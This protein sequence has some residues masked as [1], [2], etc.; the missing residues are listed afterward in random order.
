M[1]CGVYGDKTFCGVTR[2]GVHRI[3]F[4][5]NPAGQ[6]V[7]T[8]A[9]FKAKEFATVVEKYLHEHPVVA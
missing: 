7:H 6:V 4:L 5:I 9:N 1:A 3:A 8:F 2:P